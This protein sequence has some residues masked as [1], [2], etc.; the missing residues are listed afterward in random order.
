M[1]ARLVNSQWALYVLLAGL[2]AASCMLL[3]VDVRMRLGWVP[4]EQVRDALVFAHYRL[5]GS[6]LMWERL[7]GGMLAWGIA[8]AGTL[9]V[10]IRKPRREALLAVTICSG[11]TLLILAAF[12][13][14]PDSDQYAYAG[15]A[16]LVVEGYNPYAPPRLGDAMPPAQRAIASHW[17]D[18]LVADVYGPGWTSLNASF[19]SGFQHFDAQRQGFAERIAACMAFLATLVALWRA[20]AG[21]PLRTAAFAAVALN[22]VLIFEV[23]AGGHNEIWMVLFGVLAYVALRS[24]QF[25]IAVALLAF[26]AGMK[27]GYGVFILPLAAR[28]GYR[29]GFLAAAAALVLFTGLLL[30]Q[31]LPFDPRHS[32]LGSLQTVRGHGSFITYYLWRVFVHL[33]GLHGVPQA[34]FAFIVP[35]MLATLVAT[36]AIRL[37]KGHLDGILCAA[38]LLCTFL[39]AQKVEP[40]Y[41][42]ILIPLVLIPR[43]WAIATFAGVSIGSFV[44]ER[45]ILTNTDSYNMA[46]VL[47][48][49][50]SLGCWALLAPARKS[51][52]V[53]V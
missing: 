50:L 5:P 39:T 40:W 28:I 26:A 4:F 47:A 3:S 42:I 17:K 48:A 44:M 24:E 21:S 35:G 11:L 27:F 8:Y 6:W 49:A 15:Y 23:A 53:K 31:A 46:I 41:C 32:L 29:R 2:I 52:S 19:M 25:L 18:P 14:A 36:L 30:V 37:W 33:P 1:I 38:T 16:A 9:L 43:A 34:P 7:F 13:L 10:L 51:R 22:P 20:L 45:T 12:P